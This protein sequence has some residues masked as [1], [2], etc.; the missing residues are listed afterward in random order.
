MNEPPMTYNIKAACYNCGWS[1]VL[2]LPHGT[3]FFGKSDHSCPGCGCTTLR[4]AGY[5]LAAVPKKSWIWKK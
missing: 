1:G 4:H 5:S 3:P 2:T